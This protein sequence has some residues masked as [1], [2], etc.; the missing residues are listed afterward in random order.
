[1]LGR[2]LIIKTLMHYCDIVWEYDYNSDR[3]YIHHDK[4][5]SICQGKWFSTDDLIAF[6][7]DNYVFGIDSSAWDMYL[8][9]DYIRGLF[10]FETQKTSFTCGSAPK[11]EALNGTISTLNV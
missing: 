9:R 1:M 3:I 4:V 7:K 5:A 6:F 8:N 2:D 11:T 10:R